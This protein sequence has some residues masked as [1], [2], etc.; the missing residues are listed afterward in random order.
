[1]SELS[2]EIPRALGSDFIFSM[3]LMFAKEEQ[4]MGLTPCVKIADNVITS[5]TQQLYLPGSCIG[6]EYESCTQ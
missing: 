2:T 3:A 6:F 5:I 4:M 1:M